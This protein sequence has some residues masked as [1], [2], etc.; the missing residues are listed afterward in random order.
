[1]AD[2]VGGDHVEVLVQHFRARV[3]LDG[4][5]LRREAHDKSAGGP[6]GDC[7]MTS[8]VRSMLR[9]SLSAV[10][11]IFWAAAWPAGNQPRPPSR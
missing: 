8:V 9:S 6:R 2:F 4:F 3:L 1:M 11:L 10:F 7:A 5:G